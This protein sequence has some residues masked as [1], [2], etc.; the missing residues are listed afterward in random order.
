MKQINCVYKFF[1]EII[2]ALSLSSADKSKRH[3]RLSLVLFSEQ[4]I[5]FFY[6]LANSEFSKGRK[7]DEF[8]PL[9][10]ERVSADWIGVD[11]ATERWCKW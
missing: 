8:V 6:S 7:N 4:N 5:T 9:S 10:R 3:N 1:I 2:E 11:D